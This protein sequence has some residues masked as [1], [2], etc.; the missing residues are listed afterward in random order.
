MDEVDPRRPGVRR[1]VVCRYP[2]KRNI[3]L[4][5]TPVVLL[6]EVEKA[7]ERSRCPTVPRKEGICFAAARVN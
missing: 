6:E 7:R 2:R 1:E 3:E 4:D 5:G